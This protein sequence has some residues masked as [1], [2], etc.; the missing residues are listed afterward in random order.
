[1]KSFDRVTEFTAPYGMFPASVYRIDESDRPN[2][3]EQV[4]NGVR[5]SP[6]YYLRLYPV[7]FVFRGNYS[8]M[9]SDAKAL[10]SAAS[11][12]RNPRLMDMCR[13][14]L[15]GSSAGTPLYRAQCTAKVMTTRHSIQLCQAI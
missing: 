5:L 12:R 8:L 14:S 7:W 15:S 4:E 2:F 3:R 9:L 11:I 1:M 13:G 10:A 6:E